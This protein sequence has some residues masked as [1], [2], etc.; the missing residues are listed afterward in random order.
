MIENE[1]FKTNNLLLKMA[2]WNLNGGINKKANWLYRYVVENKIDILNINESRL[3]KKNERS[4]FKLFPGYKIITSE[5]IGDDNAKWGTLILVK[6]ILFE[7]ITKIKIWE[8]HR[9]ITFNLNLTKLGSYDSNFELITL[10]SCYGP[11]TSDNK[12]KNQYWNT[13]IDFIETLSNSAIII[14]DLNV[15]YEIKDNKYKSEVHAFEILLENIIN[16]PLQTTTEYTFFKG[17]KKTRVD[18]ILPS[19]EWKFKTKEA[20]INNLCPGLSPDHRMV[21]CTIELPISANLNNNVTIQTREVIDKQSINTNNIKKYQSKLEKLQSIQ[22]QDINF[23]NME[24]ER[25]ITSVAHEVFTYKKVSSGF[26]ITKMPK[27]IRNIQVNLRRLIKAKLAIPKLEPHKLIPKS[28]RNLNINDDLYRIQVPKTMDTIEIQ[29]LKDDINTTKKRVSRVFKEKLRIYYSDKLAKAIELAKNKYKVSPK[30]FY[31]NLNINNHFNQQKNLNTLKTKNVITNDPTKVKLEVEQF[32]TKLFESNKEK[33]S[34][35]KEWLHTEHIIQATTRI[36]KYSSHLQTKITLSEIKETIKNLR[37]DKATPT[38]LTNELVKIVDK[39]TMKEIK[40]LFNK[41]LNEEEIPVDW[42]I[43]KTLPIYKSGDPLNI[44]NYRP[45]TM[46]PTLYKI[47]ISIINKRLIFVL[48]KAEVLFKDPSGFR[49]GRSVLNNLYTL[50]EIIQ[51]SKIN[52]DQLAICYLDIHKC[53]DSIEHWVIKET[54][55]A[56]NLPLPFVNLITNIYENNST[57]VIAANG[58]TN[59][60]PMTRGVKQG[61]PMS[62]IIF[63][64]ILNPLLFW[65]H[66]TSNGVEIFKNKFTILPF[67]MIWLCLAE[68][69]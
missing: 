61:C 60:I 63:L 30:Q 47:F 15:H 2:T 57:Q 34:E 42:K 8:D 7:C 18:Y 58:L 62:P 39:N 67:A 46:A 16:D 69:Q 51:Q 55:E 43:N 53:Y 56:Y 5:A 14:G 49:Q 20:G 23:I 25:R 40:N 33:T 41:I 68:M 6:D 52:N 12:T 3:R 54:M 24:I 28:I 22:D 35:V 45:I 10:I 4:L 29:N 11:S 9:T 36:Q 32:Y 19:H 65:I 59:N 27:E 17:T 66:E 38:E 21:W 50:L 64:L 31:R 44:Q 37:K 48:E 26:R 13:I 1:N